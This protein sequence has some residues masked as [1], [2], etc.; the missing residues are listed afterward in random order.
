MHDY[1][2]SSGKLLQLFIIITWGLKAIIL[3]FLI[4]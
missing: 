3:V 2:I 4:H 1:S